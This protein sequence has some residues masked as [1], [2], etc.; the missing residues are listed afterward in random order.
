[1]QENEDGKQVKNLLATE[2]AEENFAFRPKKEKTSVLDAIFGCCSS[3]KKSK[4]PPLLEK[5]P[6]T[7]NTR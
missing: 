5:K 6:P 4:E 2:E 1:M 7:A 3:K